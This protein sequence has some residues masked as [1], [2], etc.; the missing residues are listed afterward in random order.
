[1]TFLAFEFSGLGWIQG[2][3]R[4][5]KRLWNSQEGACVFLL[6]SYRG[7]GYPLV[8]VQV[9]P[10]PKASAGPHVCPEPKAE[11]TDQL[12][13]SPDPSGRGH[14]PRGPAGTTERNQGPSTPR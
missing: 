3:T 5:P 1:M 10:A 9:P 13:R 14:Q 8:P 7:A 6:T 2:C 12:A 4:S 11:A